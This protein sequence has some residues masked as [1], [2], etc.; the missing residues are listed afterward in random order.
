MAETLHDAVAMN[1]NRRIIIERRSQG[2]FY[3]IGQDHALAEPVILECADYHAAIVTAESLQKS[4]A[5]T[6]AT[7]VDK[8]ACPNA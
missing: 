5:F 6:G 4:T 3:V 1:Q 8:R 7:I 2:G